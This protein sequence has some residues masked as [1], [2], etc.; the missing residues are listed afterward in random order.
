MLPLNKPSECIATIGGTFDT[1]HAGH[2]EYIRLAF[3]FAEYVRIYVSADEFVQDHKRYSLRPFEARVEKLLEYLQQNFEFSR[4]QIRR[5]RSLEE[6]REDYLE[7]PGLREHLHLAIV[8]PEYYD[9][10]QELNRQREARGIKSFLT[11]VK[12]RT[13]TRDRRDLSSYEVRKRLPSS[14]K[15][16]LRQDLL[17]RQIAL[18]L[19]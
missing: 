9:F 14:G 5:L 2:K 6:L 12:Q 16:A 4:Y 19:A 13:L 1:L 18:P 17:R 8:T 11:L 15:H 7:T 3:N 10:F